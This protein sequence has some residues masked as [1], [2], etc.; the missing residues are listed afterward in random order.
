MIR[1]ILSC[2]E[3][4]EGL[5]TAERARASELA[6]SRG[7]FFP[8]LAPGFSD[9]SLQPFGAVTCWTQ[10]YGL[11]YA[12]ALR[13]SPST[14]DLR[15]CGVVPAKK[16][17]PRFSVAMG[18]CSPVYHHR[19]AFFYATPQGANTTEPCRSFPHAFLL[20]LLLLFFARVCILLLSSLLAARAAG[21]RFGASLASAHT[22][23]AGGRFLFFLTASLETAPMS[24]FRRKCAPPQQLYVCGI[25]A[26][27]L[28]VCVCVSLARA[29][30]FPVLFFVQSIGAR[31]T[32]NARWQSASALTGLFRALTGEE[33][34]LPFLPIPLLPP[35]TPVLFA[36]TMGRGRSS[37]ACRRCQEQGP[38]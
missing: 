20:L 24:S 4:R 38:Q 9:C 22:G 31:K 33:G 18:A 25:G 35:R 30:S 7:F 19:Q 14:Q 13:S 11:R 32:F 28:C 15:L 27:A 1:P 23:P 16:A 5:A 29:V 12:S 3:C 10:Q 26:R 17:A 8:P 2:R 6:T 36:C 34:G 21:K 37:S